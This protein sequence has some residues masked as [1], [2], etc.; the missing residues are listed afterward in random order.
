LS[1]SI[2]LTLKAP[3]QLSIPSPDVFAGGEEEHLVARLNHGRALAGDAAV[4]AEDGD[5]AGVDVGNVLAQVLD[6]MRHQRP[7]GKRAHRDQ[8]GGAT[9]ELQH[10]QRFG[11]LDQLQQV[12]GDA[13]LGPDDVG[14]AEALLARQLRVGLQFGVAHAC[15]ARGDIEQVGG[16]LAGHQVGLVGAG[17][18]DQHV[19]VFRAGLLQHRRLRGVAHQAAQVVAILQV[20]HARAVGVDDRDVVGFRDE[21]FGHRGADAASAENDDLHADRRA[22]LLRR[23]RPARRRDRCRRRAPRPRTG[24]R[25]AT[26]PRR[27]A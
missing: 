16:D 21:A 20:G 6:R 7:A 5:D 19:A 26:A 4:V 11:E 9:G 22:L 13:L 1:N 2:S 10:L 27:A 18:R 3:P 25:R 12:V 14:G 17:D 23:G 24:G 15:D 8:A